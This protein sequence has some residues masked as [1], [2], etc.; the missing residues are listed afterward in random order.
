MRYTRSFSLRLFRAVLS[1]HPRLV[2]EKSAEEK[3]HRAGGF[4][5]PTE[6]PWRKRELSLAQF[7][8]ASKQPSVV[9]YCINI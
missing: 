7:D 1:S 9:L 6:P 4:S 5:L 8:A 2:Q 3:T